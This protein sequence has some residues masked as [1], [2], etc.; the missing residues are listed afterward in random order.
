M[1]VRTVPESGHWPLVPFLTRT[2]SISGS[3]GLRPKTGVMIAR[4]PPFTLMSPVLYTQRHSWPRL[5]SRASDTWRGSLSPSLVSL[6]QGPQDVWPS[7]LLCLHW[8]L[9]SVYPSAEP[10]FCSVP[11]LGG[12][13]GPCACPQVPTP[14][15]ISEGAWRGHDQGGSAAAQG[16]GTP[17]SPRQRPLRRLVAP[18]PLAATHEGPSPLPPVGQGQRFRAQAPLSWRREPPRWLRRGPRIAEVFLFRAVR[19]PKLSL[20]A[21]MGNESLCPC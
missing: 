11:A 16:Q 13:N 4:R 9:L 21:C 15:G 8:V 3:W 10:S 20:T 1:K 19:F 12:R 5:T 2:G 14:G 7:F 17:V 6:L 18:L